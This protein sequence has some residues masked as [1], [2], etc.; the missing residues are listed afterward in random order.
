MQV[1]LFNMQML[2]KLQFTVEQLYNF[3]LH[4]NNRLKIVPHRLK[5]LRRLAQYF[6]LFFFV[7]TNG[8]WKDLDTA[9][10][11]QKL[12]G[13]KQEA[14]DSWTS[15]NGG[16]G[17]WWVGGGQGEL[18]DAVGIQSAENKNFMKHVFFFLA[19]SMTML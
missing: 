7:C 14:A 18:S 3:I 16:W 4:T 1:I 9:M 15:L 10:V 8:S 19:L 5:N 12:C 6:H 17:S 2:L 13:G 11:I